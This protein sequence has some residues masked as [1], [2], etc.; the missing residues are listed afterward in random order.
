MLAKEDYEPLEQMLE[1]GASTTDIEEAFIRNTHR[2]VESLNASSEQ[3][4]E[5]IIRRWGL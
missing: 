3:D 5:P 1:E 2:V 4:L